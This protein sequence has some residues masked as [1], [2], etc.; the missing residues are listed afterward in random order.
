MKISDIW[1]RSAKNTDPIKPTSDYCSDYNNQSP[2]IK[3]TP[4]LLE[5]LENIKMPSGCKLSRIEPYSNHKDS[6]VTINT[7]VIGI[8]I[9]GR[10][11]FESYFNMSSSPTSQSRYINDISSGVIRI[12][13]KESYIK[14]VNLRLKISEIIDS[15]NRISTSDTGTTYE[16]ESHLI[17]SLV[18]NRTLIDQSIN[19][20]KSMSS[21]FYPIEIDVNRFGIRSRVREFDISRTISDFIG[22]TR[23]II[24]D[25]FKKEVSYYNIKISLNKELKDFKENINEDIIGDCFAHV[26]DIVG[27]DSSEHQIKF[28]GESVMPSG[29]IYTNQ[30]TNIYWRAA[31]K[32][33]S[34]KEND[35][36]EI[37]INDKSLDILY[38]ITD[39]IS[40]LRGFYEKCDISLNFKNDCIHIDIKPILETLKS[41]EYKN[42]MEPQQYERERLDY[43]QRR[44]NNKFVNTLRSDIY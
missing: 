42:M 10:H 32:L 2:T 20:H 27:N 39:G 44:S 22:Q 14:S 13:D 19:T 5:R 40:K 4:S 16:Y 30:P 8:A 31:F 9:E 12:D 29:R 37:K 21:N 34:K 28:F 35:G 23:R 7:F 3:Q 43:Y 6:G 11:F 36:I 25:N 17:D 15:N 26:I 24:E 18:V 41:S 33:K 38:E 1:K